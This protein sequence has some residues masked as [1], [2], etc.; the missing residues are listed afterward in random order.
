VI[1]D[2]LGHAAG[3]QLLVSIAGRLRDCLRSSDTVA[4]LGGDEFVLLL[5][6]TTDEFGVH[7]VTRRIEEA[8]RASH[9]LEGHEVYI[10]ASIGIVLS[11]QG[12]TNPNDVLRDADIAM[13]RAKALGKAR[14]EIFNLE[15]RTEAISRL[16]LENDLRRAVERQEFQLYYQ[17][18]FSL[19]PPVLMGFEAL[20]RW[21]H[22]E[23]GLLLPGEFIHVAEESGIILQMGEWVLNEACGQMKKWREEFPD[24]SR[25]A[26]NVNISGRQFIQPDFVD[27]IQKT[28]ERVGLDA[29]A[30]KLEITE[31][32]LIDSQ[33]RAGEVFTR[34]C[35]LGVQLQIDDFG[36]GYSSLG[37]LQHYPVHTIKIDKSFVQE[38]G[39]GKKGT[40]LIRA[41]VTMARD[42]GM[43]TIAE[44]VETRDQ[45]D[46]LKSLSCQYGQ[47]FLLSRP[48][49]RMAAEGVIAGIAG[50]RTRVP[51]KLGVDSFGTI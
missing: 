22:P 12:Y 34:L 8:L 21:N 25:L 45:L 36:T 33:A 50:L 7:R 35:E 40:E 15:L 4:R 28:L 24:Q 16:E 32:V 17:P 38:M 43:E 39:H 46:E 6:N 2:S 23:R 1:N 48:L 30:L 5:E 20:I 9:N 31:S 19:D 13:Y 44:G 37:Y 14:C 47:G 11:L 10:T 29:G 49:D 41:I 3:D 26:I 27:Q 18:I 51:W 42:L